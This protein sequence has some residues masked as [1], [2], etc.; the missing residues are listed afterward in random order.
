MKPLL[1]SFGVLCSLVAFPL[2]HAANEHIVSEL[3][4]RL[5]GEQN[6]TEQ[7]RIDSVTATRLGGILGATAEQILVFIHKGIVTT[8]AGDLSQVCV[9]RNAAI[10]AEEKIIEPLED[11]SDCLQ[12]IRN[13][14]ESEYKIVEMEFFA[15]QHTA[16]FSRWWDG[17]LAS[18]DDFDVLADLNLVDRQF[19]DIDALLLQAPKPDTAIRN[20]FSLAE[21]NYRLPIGIATGAGQNL[22][23]ASDYD[24]GSKSGLSFAASSGCAAGEVS[25]YG[26]LVCVPQ[27]CTDFMCI[28]VKPI[29]G[30]R[31][32]VATLGKKETKSTVGN[33]VA[34]LKAIATR[35]KDASQST[36]TRN[37]NQGH[38]WSQMFNWDQL[39]HA[40]FT[41]VAR[42]IPI[43]DGLIAPNGSEAKKQT[44]QYGYDTDTNTFTFENAPAKTN[45][46]DNRVNAL[47]PIAQASEEQQHTVDTVY[48]EFK[49][50][51]NE[52]GLCN[53]DPD[54]SSYDLL[55]AFKADCE[56]YGNRAKPG[57]IDRNLDA[58]A[59]DLLRRAD[60][61]PLDSSAS[62]FIKTIEMRQQF[63]E[64]ISKQTAALSQ[65][66]ESFLQTVQ[67]I[68][69][70]A[71]RQAQYSCGIK[72]QTCATQNSSPTS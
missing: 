44:Y 8:D 52:L 31:E 59:K 49:K 2:A 10:A 71:L 62:Y 64:Q 28:K 27:Y 37:T 68:N 65:S 58:C 38:W 1:F 24:I 6:I 4:T 39:R 18:N 19:Y 30:Y 50:V 13:L 12:R 9:Y 16:A 11:M 61:N 29:P 60:N 45:S 21:S 14:W 17:H 42:P 7:S 20:T 69:L 55:E 57:S 36:P 26:G 33:L 46:I 15:T 34:D 41:A 40:N 56:L 32:T 48:A 25:M 54:C 3:Y 5:A 51:H 67:G 43:F 22:A 70:C 23:T 53:A 35:L 63:D 72:K 47:P 66:I